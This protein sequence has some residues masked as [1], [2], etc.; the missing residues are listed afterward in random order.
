M[1]KITLVIAIFSLFL[2]LTPAFAVEAS[3]FVRV[4]MSSIPLSSKLKKEY[5]GYKYEIVN[6][7]K[8][9]VKLVNAQIIHGRDGG[10]AAAA[11]DDGNGV[12]TLWAVMGPL[13]LFTFGIGW[14]VGLIATPVVLLTSK[15]KN[16]KARR[17]GQ[18]F[19]N[20]VDLGALASGGSTEVQTLVP[21]GST[22]QMKL[23]IQDPNTNELLM[24]TR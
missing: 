2:N 5:S 4:E 1:K 22:P 7:S 21:V 16:K 3:D 11:V 17:E 13:G 19:T 10:A 23:T 6:D 8:Q 9:A 18:S 14:A 15:G 20:L 12:G 24:I